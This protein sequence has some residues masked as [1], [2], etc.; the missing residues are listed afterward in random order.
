[1]IGKRGKNWNYSKD[2]L[3]VKEF[4]NEH[5]ANFTPKDLSKFSFGLS[6]LLNIVYYQ[7]YNVIN[8][9]HCI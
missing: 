5:R 6:H 1:M 9:V 7:S 2:R 8:L 4:Y 3:Y